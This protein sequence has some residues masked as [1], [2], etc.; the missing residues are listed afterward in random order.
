MDYH[1]LYINIQDNTFQSKFLKKEDMCNECNTASVTHCCNKC[2]NGVCSKNDCGWIFPHRGQT[3][4]IICD[5][6]VEMIDQKLTLLIDYGKLSLLKKKINN[7]NERKIQIIKQKEKEE[8]QRRVGP[9]GGIS[10]K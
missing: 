10:Y 3:N 9:Y 1:N 8:R 4:Y 7:K 6:C 5:T 2:G